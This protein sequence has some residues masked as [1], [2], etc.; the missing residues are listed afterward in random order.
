MT[1]QI[2]DAEVAD[3]GAILELNK[4]SEHFL[5]PMTMDSLRALNADAALH[6]VV[7]ADSEVVSFLL[8]MPSHS[9]YTSVNYRW[10]CERYSSFLYIDRIVVSTHH[11]GRKL[12]RLLYEELF[13]F[14]KQHEITHITA[15]FDVEPPNEA[16]RRF[17]ASF[18][19]SEVG[20]QWLN[21]RKK[22]VSMQ[23]AVL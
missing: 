23:L 19:F 6:K 1:Y 14:A 9:N 2:R 8:V 15:E 18:G 10:F 4:E 13:D 11:Q 22:Q 5:S 7:E 17:H 16:S 12:G 21:A 3:F 20:T